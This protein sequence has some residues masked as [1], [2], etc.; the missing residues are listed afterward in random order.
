MMRA[1]SGKSP[2]SA[3][4]RA[5]SAVL[6]NP[7]RTKPVDLQQTQWGNNVKGVS[8]PENFF[9]L[10]GNIAIGWLQWGCS[11]NIDAKEELFCFEFEL[12]RVQLCMC[13]HECVCACMCVC[14]YV[15]VCMHACM[16]AYV[17]AC[18]CMHVRAC[19]HVYLP[20][21]YLLLVCMHTNKYPAQAKEPCGLCASV[22]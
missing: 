8:L 13:E 4:Y 6:G 11:I 12:R 20:T 16:R 7:S 19:M 5:S 17:H 1:A 14:V 15:C 21:H 18:M 2:T 22:H 9:F 3:R 10:C